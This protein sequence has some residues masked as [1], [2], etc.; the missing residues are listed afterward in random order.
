MTKQRKVDENTYSEPVQLLPIGQLMPSILLPILIPILM[1]KKILP[2]GMLY[3]MAIF[4]TS[5]YKFI[6]ST[7]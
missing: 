6:R 5:Y 7:H 4:M 3:L 2:E 1:V